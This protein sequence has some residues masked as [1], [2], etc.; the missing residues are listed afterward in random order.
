VCQRLEFDEDTTAQVSMSVI[1]AGTNAIQHG[2]KKDP[3]KIVDIEF[4]LMPDALE[5]VVQDSGSGFDVSRVNGDV[6]SPSTSSILGAAAS[7]SCA[8]A[9]TGWA[10]GSP[11][12]GAGP[13]VRTVPQGRQSLAGRRCGSRRRL[14]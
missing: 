12:Q 14:G 13:L 10:S 2:H 4:R 8:P 6:T 9:W 5:V 11:V 7:S 3:S 1:E